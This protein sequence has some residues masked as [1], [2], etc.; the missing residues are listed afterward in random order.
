MEG[1]YLLAETLAGTARRQDAERWAR[2][3]ARRAPN[4][5]RTQQLLTRIQK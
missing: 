3:A 1:P 4:D 2:E 5:P